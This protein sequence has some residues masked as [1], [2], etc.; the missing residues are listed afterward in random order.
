MVDAHQ[1]THV[2]NGAQHVVDYH[3]CMRTM[4]GVLSGTVWNADV[5][6]LLTLS[7]ACP[8]LSANRLTITGDA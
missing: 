7:I 5:V 2:I 1:G 8:S 3:L 4:A 6:E